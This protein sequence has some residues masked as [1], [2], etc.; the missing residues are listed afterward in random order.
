MRLA[1]F[2]NGELFGRITTVPWAVKFPTEVYDSRYRVPEGF[3]GTIPRDELRGSSAEIIER[4]ASSPEL[5]AFL[6]HGLNPRHPS[7]IYEALLE[8]LVLLA[9]LLVTRFR[10]PKLPHGILTGMF[11][12]IYAVFRIFCEFYRLPDDGEP[13]ILGMS[14]GQFYSGFMVI[15]G[16]AFLAWGSMRGRPDT[17][18]SR[19]VA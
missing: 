18:G 17:A 14:K 5:A 4:A 3:E 7:Q 16:L 6:E 15:A 11:F 13:L 1:N 9:I 12:L 2:I 10:F 19:T 8:G